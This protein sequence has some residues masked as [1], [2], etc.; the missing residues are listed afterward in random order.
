MNEYKVEFSYNGAKGK[1][2]HEEDTSL[3]FTAD[4]AVE[5]VRN[6]YRDLPGLRIERVFVDRNNRWEVT[7]AWDI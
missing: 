7:T 6:F 4:E 3:A 5:N 1:R 2:I